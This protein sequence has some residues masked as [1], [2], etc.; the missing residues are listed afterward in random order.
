[1]SKICSVSKLHVHISLIFSGVLISYK[2]ADQTIFSQSDGGRKRMYKLWQTLEEMK[3]LKQSL[4]ERDPG[5]KRGTL[6]D[7]V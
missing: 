1:M 7:R 6:Q 2:V 5:R 4:L 3:K